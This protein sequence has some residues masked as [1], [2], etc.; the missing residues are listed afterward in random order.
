[1]PE[2]IWKSIEPA[3]WRGSEAAKNPIGSG[4]YRF[5]RW[6]PRAAVELAADTT[7][8]RGA[9]KLSRLVWSLAPDFNAALTRFLSGE[10]DLFPQLRPENL[11]EVAKH[12]ELKDVFRLG[13]RLVWVTP[14]GTALVVDVNSGSEKL[15][16]KEIDALFQT[17]K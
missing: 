13:N 6:I 8:Y 5:V 7:N 9:P 15:S 16:D 3:G 10:T 2:H 11:A 17:S 4:Q 14:S 1:M 12:P